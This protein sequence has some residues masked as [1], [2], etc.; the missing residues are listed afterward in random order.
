MRIP[1]LPRAPRILALALCLLSRTARAAED[2]LPALFLSQP[3]TNF[4]SSF[5]LSDWKFD[6]R[7]DTARQTLTAPSFFRVYHLHMNHH[8]SHLNSD[9][10]TGAQFLNFHQTLIAS[11]NVW[12][13]ER[14]LEASLSYV[15]CN[16]MPVGHTEL[17]NGLVRPPGA[18]MEAPCAPMPLGFRV[19]PIGTLGQAGTTPPLNSYNAVGHSLNLTWHSGT[20][21]AL[22]YRSL[23]DDGRNG[24]MGSTDKSPLDPAFWMWHAAVA[25]VADVWLRTQPTDIVVAVDRSGSMGLPMSPA[26]S[27]TRLAASQ[28]ALQFLGRLI[29]QVVPGGDGRPH[30]LAL[31]SFNDTATTQ[32]N[33]T[34]L[35]SA[36]FASAWSNAVVSLTASGASGIP[37]GIN[38]AR[39]LALSG[40]NENRAVLVLSDGSTG[41]ST[42]LCTACGTNCQ[43]SG[44]CS[45]GGHDH[46]NGH[47]PTVPVHTIAVGPS[48]YETG[49]QLTRTAVHQTGIPWSADADAF[50]LKQRMIHFLAQEFEAG[51]SLTTN[52]ALASG[53]ARSTAV[54][55]PVSGDPAVTFVLL[56]DRPVTPG[57]LSL[58]VTSP[59][60]TVLNL[61]NPAIGVTTAGLFQVV[62]VGVP[63]SGGND[64]NWTVRVARRTGSGPGEDQRLHIAVLGNGWGRVE[65]APSTPYAYT[66]EPVRVTFR[67]RE[68]YWPTNG[69]DSVTA[70]A[71]VTSPTTGTGE[72]AAGLGLG[73]ASIFQGDER[74]GL[75]LA[76]DGIAGSLASRTTS[77]LSLG[78]A[79]PGADG[80]GGDRHPSDHYYSAWFVPTRDG[81]HQFAA[82]FTFVAAGR[83]FV[84]EAHYSLRVQPRM[85]T[86]SQLVAGTQT[87]NL[88]GEIITPFTFTPRDILD[89]KVGPGRAAEVLLRPAD[90]GISVGPVTDLGGGAY[91]VTTTGLVPGVPSLTSRQPGRNAVNCGTTTVPAFASKPE[92]YSHKPGEAIVVWSTTAPATALVEAGES[93]GTWTSTATSPAGTEHRVVLDG[94]RG[95]RRYFI[96][97]TNRHASGREVCSQLVEFITPPPSVTRITVDRLGY[98]GAV[99]NW[100]TG[101]VFLSEPLD[102]PRTVALSTAQTFNTDNPFTNA[103]ATVTIPANATSVEWSLLAG[104]VERDV[105]LHASVLLGD[106]PP[107]VILKLIPPD[108]QVLTAPDPAG[109][110]TTNS[111]VRID[112]Y[113]RILDLPVQTESALFLKLQA[114][115]QSVLT[116]ENA[117]PDQIRIRY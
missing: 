77:N 84:R 85:S 5:T 59:A 31:V 43:C 115:T 104:P 63:P 41:S 30:R 106:F 45:C 1:P 48:W 23:L 17:N 26:G 57:N 3:A 78:D 13:M 25:D 71:V 60:G 110:F 92:V 97:I 7:D 6:S 32:L 107:H 94:L 38:A 19:P 93:I 98:N 46:G 79:G 14:G 68:S 66:G 72:A 64:G 80:L 56:W 90:E 86:A 28:E 50:Q 55:V 54:S 102:Q 22:G 42:S 9:A 99:S 89:Q 8:A 108:T 70:A 75:Q 12:R 91:Q 49:S 40:T 39:D 52:L 105:E 109:P 96:R 116:L 35:N 21:F 2:D 33:L 61:A 58:E 113:H 101:R 16:P 76:L 44:G 82:R 67:V 62:R 88:A 87:T 11:Y 4:H 73:A 112:P 111:S 100:I 83:T 47:G 37:A 24:D 27:T 81:D 29:P 18:P 20:H 65:P 15:A 53:T 51:V 117:T 36:G 103:T 74:S 114:P 69:F 10:D 34:A 95:N